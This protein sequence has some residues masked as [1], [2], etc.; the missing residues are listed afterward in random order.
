MIQSD[1]LSRRADHILNKDEDNK[2][3]ILL[4]SDLFL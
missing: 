2:E 1:T 4:P 3:M